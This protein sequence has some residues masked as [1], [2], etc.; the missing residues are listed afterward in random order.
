VEEKVHRRDEGVLHSGAPGGRKTTDVCSHK[1]KRLI[2]YIGRKRG[3]A[4]CGE[5]ACLARFGQYKKLRA[6]DKEILKRNIENTARWNDSRAAF[7]RS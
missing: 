2:R 5:K 3:G 1:V 4:V 7:V 6:E